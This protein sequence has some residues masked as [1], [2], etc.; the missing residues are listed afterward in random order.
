MLPTIDNSVL[1]VIDAQVGFVS[2]ASAQAVPI[3][4]D[5]LARW[6]GAGGATVMT[7]FVNGEDSSYVRII[8]W[9]ALMPGSVG[10]EFAPEVAPYAESASLVVRKQG[11]TALTPAVRK[12]ISETGRENVWIC[13]LD[14][15]SC[16]LATSFSVFES[17]LTP[18]IITDACASHAGAHVHEAGLLVAGRNIGSGQLVTTADVPAEVRAWRASAVVHE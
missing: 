6:Q 1:L 8:G 10:V 11:Y 7:Q 15:E 13:G 12:F 18:W 4:A 3:I 17:G 9:S 16:V 2:P 14:T 5:L